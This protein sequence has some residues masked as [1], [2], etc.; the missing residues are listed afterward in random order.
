MIRSVDCD[1]NSFLCD[2][3]Q[4]LTVSR[5]IFRHFDAVFTGAVELDWAQIEAKVIRK[6][7]FHV[8]QNVK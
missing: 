7:S 2:I 5:N 1:V 6:F 3:D 8:M 4:S